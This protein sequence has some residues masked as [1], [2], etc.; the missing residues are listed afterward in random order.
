MGYYKYNT[1][2]HAGEEFTIFKEKAVDGKFY[3]HWNIFLK[4]L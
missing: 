2:K 3:V 4:E 1:I